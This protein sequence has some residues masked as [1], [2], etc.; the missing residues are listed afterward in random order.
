[1]PP[2][3]DEEAESEVVVTEMRCNLNGRGEAQEGQDEVPAKRHC[4]GGQA[5]METEE[6]GETARAV[7]AMILP[8]T[9]L[10]P[11]TPATP[12]AM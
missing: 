12:A 2:I 5:E 11:A 8:L 9:P 3:P 6:A 7:P 1:M 10:T 4:S